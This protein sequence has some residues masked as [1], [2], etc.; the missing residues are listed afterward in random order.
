MT[1]A[2]DWPESEQKVSDLGKNQGG[3]RK[4]KGRE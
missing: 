4:G 3:E 2:V 1:A